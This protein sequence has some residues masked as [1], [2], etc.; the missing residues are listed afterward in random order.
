MRYFYQPIIVYSIFFYYFISILINQSNP[1]FASFLNKQKYPLTRSSKTIRELRT[2]SSF[3]EEVVD[4][5]E[6]E[7]RTLLQKKQ[8][9]RLTCK[10]FPR[11]C[12]FKG[13][14]GPN[15]SK[16]KCVNAVRDRYNCGRCEKK[17]KFDQ[18]CCN[19]KCVNSSFNSTGSIAE[20]ANNSCSIWQ[21]LCF[22]PL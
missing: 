15:C 16:K 22:W 5:D 10:S 12:G 20:G 3:F 7:G 18:I 19:E 21:P 2:K 17:C 8:T 11:T 13:S 6:V 14:P 1:I 9:L 4:V